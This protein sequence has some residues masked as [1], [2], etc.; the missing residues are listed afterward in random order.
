MEVLWF[1]VDNWALTLFVIALCYALWW[2]AEDDG[3]AKD[4]RKMRELRK[5]VEESID[6]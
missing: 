5:K 1:F 6:D 3:T 4:L 2:A